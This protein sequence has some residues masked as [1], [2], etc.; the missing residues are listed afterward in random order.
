MSGDVTEG[1]YI[2]AEPVPA[3]TRGVD[4]VCAATGNHGNGTAPPSHVVVNM[5]CTEKY[6][7]GRSVICFLRIPTHNEGP[8]G[9]QGHRTLSIRPT[10]DLI[11]RQNRPIDHGTLPPSIL[12]LR[13]RDLSAR[14]NGRPRGPDRRMIH[15]LQSQRL[16]TRPAIPPSRSTQ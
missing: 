14:R 7:V 16:R 1:R 12:G 8:F 6:G 11:H 9:H 5:E 10:H 3:A 4:R 15:D 2:A 13:L